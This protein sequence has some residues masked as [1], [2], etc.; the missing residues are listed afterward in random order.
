M[1]KLIPHDN[2]FQDLFDFRRD[3]DQIFNRFLS[4]PSAHEESAMTTA[5]FSPAIDSH[6]GSSGPIS[7]EQPLSTKRSLQ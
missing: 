4:W 2:F 5:G 1:T 6:F 7:F 3:F